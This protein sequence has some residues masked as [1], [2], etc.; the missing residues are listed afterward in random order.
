M[1][2]WHLLDGPAGERLTWTLLHFLW[3]GLLI[4][5]T[6]EL[7][8][9]L[10]RLRQ[11]KIRYAILVVALALMAL[12]PP[13]T[14]LI[15][16]IPS[17]QTASGP[18]TPALTL[19]P[20]I[21]EPTSLPILEDRPRSTRMYRFTRSQRRCPGLFLSERVDAW[22]QDVA[23]VSPYCLLLWLAGVLLLSLRL[24]LSLAGVHFLLRS[25]LTSSE[26]L[27][28]CAGNLARRLSLSS[29]PDLAVS[30]RLHEALVIG[31]WRPVILL[32]MAW[33]ADMPPEA[34]EAVIAHELAHIAAGTCG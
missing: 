1:G 13:A 5:V 18:G 20:E 4:V 28:Q 29:L 16:D 15:L 8:L 30:Q 12:C 14:F 26:A 11:A 10:L 32:P 3:Q 21:G 7:L 25:R 9:G 2:P 17:A 31:L 6:A 33:A 22:R 23:L 34:L 24:T 19:T 27:R